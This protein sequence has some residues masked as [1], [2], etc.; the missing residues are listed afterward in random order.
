[1]PIQNI[2]QKFHHI[3]TNGEAVF[4]EDLIKIQFYKKKRLALEKDVQT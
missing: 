2:L 1:M 3:W 4:A